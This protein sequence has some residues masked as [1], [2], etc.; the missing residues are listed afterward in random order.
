VK[1]PFSLSIIERVGYAIE[2]L[3]ARMILSYKSLKNKTDKII[4]RIL[5]GSKASFYSANLAINQLF[6]PELPKTLS[7][8]RITRDFE[9]AQVAVQA[10]V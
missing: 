8:D 4:T 2:I 6:C 1:P 7:G 5:I 10:E 9:F 3:S